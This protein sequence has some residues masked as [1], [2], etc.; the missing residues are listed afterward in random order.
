MNEILTIKK[1]LSKPLFTT[2]FFGAIDEVCEFFAAVS[3]VIFSNWFSIVFKLVRS[4]ADGG[5]RNHN[6]TI[7]LFSLNSNRERKKVKKKEPDS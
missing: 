7:P 1:N 3:S 2:Y 4:V 6:F 5:S